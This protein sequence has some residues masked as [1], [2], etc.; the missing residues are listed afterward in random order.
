[1]FHLS[2]SSP[3]FGHLEITAPPH[4]RQKHGSQ[5]SSANESLNVHTLRH[6]GFRHT[7]VGILRRGFY[8]ESWSK[9]FAMSQQQFQR[10]FMSGGVL[11]NHFGAKRLKP[12]RP[13]FSR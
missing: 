11:V 8:S 5:S 9:G 1:M 12:H 4:S 2:H 3:Q 10:S 13:P 7:A 6:F